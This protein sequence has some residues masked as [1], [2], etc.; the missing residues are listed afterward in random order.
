MIVSGLPY[1]NS[2][3]A[4]GGPPVHRGSRKMKEQAV[5]HRSVIFKIVAAT[6][7]KLSK[8]SEEIVVCDE[9]DQENQEGQPDLL[10]GGALLQA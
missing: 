5:G 1:S 9:Y 6:L 8:C 4:S 3:T 2:P 7:R 10:H